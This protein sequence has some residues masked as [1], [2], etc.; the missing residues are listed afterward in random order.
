MIKNIIFRYRYKLVRKAIFYAFLSI[1]FS[2]E[3]PC[4]QIMLIKSHKGRL[5]T[6]F[7]HFIVFDIFSYGGVI[8]ELMESTQKTLSNSFIPS[9]SIVSFQTILARIHFR[10]KSH[11]FWY[12]EVCS[13]HFLFRYSILKSLML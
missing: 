8:L 3:R 13:I 2:K 6:S 12:K 11:T 5:R 10:E 7:R 9:E 4:C 1:L